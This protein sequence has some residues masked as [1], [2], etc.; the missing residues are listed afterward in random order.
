MCCLS[1]PPGGNLNSPAWGRAEPFFLSP[2]RTSSPCKEGVLGIK[3][4]GW[5]L[6]PW[7]SCHHSPL[8]HHAQ[9]V[10]RCGLGCYEETAPGEPAPTVATPRKAGVPHQLTSPTGLGLL[11]LYFFLILDPSQSE[12][13]SF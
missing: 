10:A 2:H 11:V 5:P 7:S 13:L 6:T 3:R 4:Q 9:G 1:S 12:I 8:H